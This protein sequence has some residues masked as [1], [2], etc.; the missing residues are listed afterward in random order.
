ML[1]FEFRKALPFALSVFTSLVVGVPQ[2]NAQALVWEGVHGGDPRVLT[3][4]GAELWIGSSDGTITRLRI[5]DGR[6]ETFHP[7]AT[8][9]LPAGAVIDLAI[10][11]RGHVW[12]ATSRGL[13]RFDGESW[14]KV[15]H[16]AF[17]FGPLPEGYAGAVVSVS[18]GADD[19]VWIATSFGV[20]A[21]DGT[22]WTAFDAET[23]G[24]PGEAAGNLY[25]TGMG[26]STEGKLWV[27]L[28]GHGLWTYNETEGWEQVDTLDSFPWSGTVL[29]VH[30]DLGGGVWVGFG[31]IWGQPEGLASF[32]GAAWHVYQ[33]DV[34]S[35][36]IVAVEADGSVWTA[37]AAGTHAEN[38]LYRFD[39]AT[40]TSRTVCERSSSG[41]ADI[42]VDE[43][44]TLWVP[45]SGGV[46]RYGEGDVQSYVTGPLGGEMVDLAAAPDG[47][48]WVAIQGAAGV[49]RFDG[50]R[51]AT[52]TS[53]DVGVDPEIAHDLSATQVAIGPNGHVAIVFD[54]V[55]ARYDGEAWFVYDGN[56]GPPEPPAEPEPW[57]APPFEAVVDLV[58]DAEGGAWAAAIN[59]DGLFYLRPDG[60]AVDVTAATEADTGLSI[61]GIRALAFG[62]SGA[63]WI[64]KATG[65][66]V[67]YD[68]E[69]W[70]T[71]DLGPE[72]ALDGVTDLAFDTDGALWIGSRRGLVRYR[73]GV[74]TAMDA[75]VP[76]SARFVGRLA[77][78]PRR[79][80]WVSGG[81]GLA[82]FDG[83][84]WH[85]TQAPLAGQSAFHTRA[86]TVGA[87]GRVWVGLYDNLYTLRFEERPTATEPPARSAA[88]GYL[89]EAYPNPFRSMTRIAF[90]LPEPMP[91]RLTVYDVLGREVA[92]LAEGVRGAGQHTVTFDAGGYANGLYLYRL[93]TPRRVETGRVVR[94]R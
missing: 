50:E 64:G 9:A 56:P 63:L 39:G 93:V 12:V 4:S 46:A 82:Y 78:D 90:A 24:L 68:G 1:P 58:V 87:S 32:D 88:A 51:W 75:G 7:I 80:M 59:G 19:R 45:C 10:D 35:A 13:A 44:G 38:T 29:S 11:A 76:P 43:D 3:R 60:T 57:P 65:E 70:E 31:E 73:Q 66:V 21:Y 2:G 85:V 28:G 71:I 37:G 27:G 81:R 23:I 16:D 25:I 15:E 52:I 91:V 83:D 92:V 5:G 84:A 67:R 53:K 8:P 74:A 89:R 62:P 20:A 69:R 34:P 26:F 49:S 55:L 22:A 54:G 61:S 86:L 72:V 94:V 42:E 40:W 47:S 79:G 18:V 33:D 77:A 14:T 30:A 17:G 36:E 41:I 48:V 6:F